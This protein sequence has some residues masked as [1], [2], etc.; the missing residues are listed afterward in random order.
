MKS[1]FWPAAALA[2]LF[3]TAACGEDPLMP[4]SPSDSPF[5][6]QFTGLWNGTMQLS[7]VSGGECVGDD[8]RASTATGPTF[9][10]GTVAIIQKQSDVTAVVRSATT[11]L[12]CQYPR[13]RIPGR[14]RPQFRI[15]RRGGPVSLFQRECARTRADRLNDDGPPERQSDDRYR[16]DEL[17]RVFRQ[18][19]GQP[20]E[21][22]CR[23]HHAAPVRCEPTVD[24][25][26]IV[27]GR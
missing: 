24:T 1:R 8:L 5:A 27:T 17:Q 22:N 2:A 11:G 19:R 15:V 12:S 16:H 20:A 13:Y 26:S 4:V 25:V 10:F 3:A 7:A 21:T 6:T 9:D 23:A 14:L 18:H